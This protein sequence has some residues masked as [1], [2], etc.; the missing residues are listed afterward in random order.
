MR[1]RLDLA[2]SIVATPRCCSSTS[3]PPASTRCSRSELWEILRDLARD[4]TTIVLTTQYLEEA[5]RLADDIIVLDHGRVVAHGTPDELKARIGQDLID[6]TVASAADLDAGRP[7]RRAAGLR[8]RR[9][10]TDDV[11]HGQRARSPKASR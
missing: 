3:P 6:I 10:S 1:R 9:R 7:S 4:G 5:D 11:L 2:A 8:R